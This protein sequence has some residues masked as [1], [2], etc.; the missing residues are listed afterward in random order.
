MDCV[1]NCLLL[2]DVQTVISSA[3]TV[4]MIESGANTGV[5]ESFDS[6][7]DSQIITI[8]EA[9]GDTKTVF[10]Y[11]GNSVDMIITYVDA[12]IDIDA[13]SGTWM[14]ATTATITLTDNDMNRNPTSDETLEIGDETDLVPTIV[15]GT[16]K[17]LASSG[18]NANM[19]K[20]CTSST[21]GVNIGDDDQ[22]A[23]SYGLNI[24]NTTDNSER[25]RIVHS[26]E[27]GSMATATA[28]WINV[29]TGHTKSSLY[30]LPGQVVLS[31]DVTCL[32]YTS[33]AADE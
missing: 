16:P 11:G 23:A 24:Y 8:D 10:S 21:G 3:T 12:T 6:N 22:G 29:T 32:L 30:N 31:Y 27:G 20:A 25:L 7:G 9:T 26:S 5:F 1:D 17:T 2:S 13:G 4:F 14:P 18:T 33:D 19:C 28:T 15:M